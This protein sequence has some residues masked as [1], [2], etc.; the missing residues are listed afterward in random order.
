MFFGPAVNVQKL[1]KPVWRHFEI[2][3][4]MQENY[5]IEGD[6]NEALNQVEIIYGL[7]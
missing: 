1:Q 6:N 7:P 5:L 2:E 4:K 3:E